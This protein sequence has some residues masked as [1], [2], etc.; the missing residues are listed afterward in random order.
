LRGSAGASAQL[1]SII[2]DLGGR[3]A[4]AF[5]DGLLEDVGTLSYASIP[6]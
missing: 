4:A 2:G 5:W 3:D 6:V 1:N